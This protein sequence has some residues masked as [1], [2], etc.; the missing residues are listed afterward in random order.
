MKISLATPLTAGGA[1]P[2]KISFLDGR[3]MYKAIYVRFA[4]AEVAAGSW[5]GVEIK[6]SNDGKSGLLIASLACENTA[7]NG[8]LIGNYGWPGTG[9]RYLRGRMSKVAHGRDG[10]TAWRRIMELLAPD[11]VLVSQAN[12]G[13]GT[14]T[15][16]TIQ[17]NWYDDLRAMLPAG[18]DIIH[19]QG[20]PEI[21]ADS[22]ADYS[23]ST[24]PPD[25][26]L[27]M[28]YTAQQVDGPMVSWY[29]SPEGCDH[30]CRYITADDV[31]QDAVHPTCAKD[32]EIWFEQMAVLK[33][34]ADAE[35]ESTSKTRFRNRAGR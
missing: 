34:D 29:Y 24:A 5:R 4:A 7:V 11:V 8:I 21:T 28:E 16:Y 20:G 27:T 12:Q 32:V 2:S 13:V 14:G 3:E 15:Y 6:A 9:Y 26:H 30:L 10:K 35:L 19:A 22:T 1:T 25:N 17:R 23:S 18:T 31:S 33:A